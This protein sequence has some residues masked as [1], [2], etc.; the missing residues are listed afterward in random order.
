MTLAHIR[1]T[2]KDWSRITVV[3]SDVSQST[4][5]GVSCAIIVLVF[6]IQPFGTGKIANAFA[7][8]VIL[9]MFF[10]MTFGIYVRDNCLVSSWF[11]WLVLISIEPCAL[12]CF[13]LQGLFTVLCGRLPCPEP[14]RWMA[15]AGRNIACFYWSRNTLCR[16]GCF[17]QKVLSFDIALSGPS[18]LMT[19][20]IEPSRFRGSSSYIR[21]YCSQS[22]K[23]TLVKVMF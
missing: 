10:N 17:F 13:C 9:W 22:V 18:R 23:V 21:L 6:L 1:L 15:S 7:P 2:D 20:K 12:R 5:V 4:V 14:A 16:S 19:S 11:K 3:N 8:I